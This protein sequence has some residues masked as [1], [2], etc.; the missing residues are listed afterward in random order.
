V[1]ARDPE[2]TVPAEVKGS[3]VRSMVAVV[4]EQGLR[5]AVIGRVSPVAAELLHDPPLPTMWIDAQVY[6][7]I[8][9]ALYEI[10]GAERL[11][12][13]NREAV[14]RG[15][16]SLLRTTAPGM[17]RLFGASPETLLSRLDRLG[18]STS[19]GVITPYVASGPT[20]GSLEM[21][22]PALRDV[23]IGAFVASGG[24]IKLV[25]DICGVSGTIGEPTWI[26]EERRNAMRFAVA[27]LAARR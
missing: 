6:N 24:A 12:H 3:L 19:R 26:D 22:F 18:A 17:L 8:L 13:L 11:R 21:E 15:L 1:S 9:Q 20:S 16:S 23:P 7:E 14:D 4:T 5:N 27:W 25:F 10:E 2:P